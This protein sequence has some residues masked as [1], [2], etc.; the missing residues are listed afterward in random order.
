MDGYVN[1]FYMNSFSGLKQIKWK[2]VIRTCHAFKSCSNFTDVLFSGYLWKL[3]GYARGTKSSKWI[4][5]WFCLKGNNCL[6]YYKTNSN[7]NLKPLQI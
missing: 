7:C 2:N 5:R 1:E 6:Y 4:R 3:K